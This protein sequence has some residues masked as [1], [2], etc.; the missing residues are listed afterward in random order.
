MEKMPTKKEEDIM[1]AGVVSTEGKEAVEENII[2]CDAGPFCPRTLEVEEHQK[3]G[4]WKWDASKV[5]LYLSAT[6]KHT[7]K[8]SGKGNE[9]RKELAGKPVLNANVLDYL[10]AH[11]YLI[12]KEWERNEERG[13]LCVFFWGTIY[14]NT[15]GV[16]FVRH[17]TL[18][19][20]GWSWG[21]MELS[22]SFWTNFK[23][24]AA[25]RAE[26]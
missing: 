10:L 16:L 20:G 26:E 25:L 14:R 4:Q 1:D 2:D 8:G 13:S 11:P 18:G 5:E 24:P 15:R 7:F 21:T 17:L 23:S 9:L 19:T 3:G 12:P 22:S 6:Q